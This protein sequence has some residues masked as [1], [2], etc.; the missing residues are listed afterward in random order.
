[1][2]A[3]K[4]AAQQV[5]FRVMIFAAQR[6]IFR[7]LRMLG[8]HSVYTGSLLNHPLGYTAAEHCL[9]LNRRIP[10]AD[11][12]RAHNQAINLHLAAQKLDGILIRPGE[13]FSF[14][15]AVGRPSAQKGYRPGLCLR[16]GWLSS[17]TGEDLSRMGDLLFWLFLHTPLDILER[18]FQPFALSPDD[19][20]DVPFGTGVRLL[21][22]FLDLRVFN[23]TSETYQIRIRL[24]GDFLRGQL[25]ADREPLFT[26]HLFEREA[27]FVRR[28]D[29]IY[30]HNQV[31]RD[32]I[33]KST[34]MLITSETLMRNDLPVRY[35]VDEAQ[36]SSAGSLPGKEA[37]CSPGTR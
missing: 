17:D 24:V 5:S 23:G 8:D 27:M 12:Q 11:M 32:T 34:G 18:H 20:R 6:R 14:W 28:E 2:M 30:R 29:G 3:R 9:P 31:C 15:R 21:Y 37:A 13:S 19:S 33:D 22:N 25:F 4:P 36:L 1:M 16:N 26:Y 7:R 35:Q 10:G